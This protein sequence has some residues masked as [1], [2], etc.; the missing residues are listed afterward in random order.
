MITPASVPD[1]TVLYR[2]RDGIYAGDLLITAVADLDLFTW[3]TAHGPVRAVDVVDGL[4]LAERPTDVLLTYC[5]ALGLVERD[6]ND[7]DRV[8]IT[9]LARAHLVAESPFDLR[10]YYGSLAERPTVKEFG[11][12]MRTGERI[13]WASAGTDQGLAAK[14]APVTGCEWSTRLTDTH[15]ASRITAAMDARAAFLGPALARAV[16]DLP[17]TALLDIGGSSG[18]YAS[19]LSSSIESMTGIGTQ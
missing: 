18:S 16:A 6:V 3:L 17:I 2:L 9:E 15:F 14:D 13:A 10:P 11:R 4:G 1:P 12:V 19:A 5:A 8:H 7:G